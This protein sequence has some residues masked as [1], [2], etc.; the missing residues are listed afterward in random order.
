MSTTKILVVVDRFSKV[1]FGMLPSSYT[2]YSVAELFST[3]ICKL[4]GFPNSIISDREPILTSQFA[5]LIQIK[6]DVFMNEFMLSS[7]N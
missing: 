5:G 6:W 3:M 1:T 4:H 2:S 7:T